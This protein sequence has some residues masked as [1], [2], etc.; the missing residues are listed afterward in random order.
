MQPPRLAGR[1]G[2]SGY[3]PGKGPIVGVLT[4]TADP[5]APE[6]FLTDVRYTVARSGETVA[7]SGRSTVYTGFQWRGRSNPAQQ[8]ADQVPWREVMTVDRDWKRMSGRW[9]TGGYDEIGIDV[10]LERLGGDPS[11]FG[12]SVTSL[13]AGATGQRVKVYGANL[14]ARIKTADIGFGQGVT[15]ARLVSATAD[16]LSVDV[17]VAADA[18]SGPRDLSI[19]TARRAAAVVVYDRVAAIQVRPTA[20]MARLGGPTFPKQV[21]QFE[22]VAFATGP[23]GKPGTP[24]D[25]LLGPVDVK[26]SLEEYT[27]TFGDDDVKFVGGIDANGLFTPS[28]D[29]P[30]P[31]RSG[32]RNNVGDVWVVAELPAE[33]TAKPL[34]AR[35]HLLVTVPVYMNWYSSETGS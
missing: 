23:D 4:V 26:W 33:G 35:G 20:G 31:E 5:A 22:A 12:A 32:S 14:P 3:Q 10:Q 21:Q 25:Q 1:W 15:V 19:A 2:I 34:R 28:V 24:D 7:R 11:V 29:G 18:K 6:A 9:F 16:E 8:P 30:N 13:K 17:D 27:A